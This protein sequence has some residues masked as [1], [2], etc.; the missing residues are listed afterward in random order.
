MDDA[1]A[2]KVHLEITS[3]QNGSEIFLNSSESGSSR[4]EWY[5]TF[6]IGNELFALVESRLKV[7]KSEHN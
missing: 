1:P 3:L 5:G 7:R 6:N 2:K 4:S